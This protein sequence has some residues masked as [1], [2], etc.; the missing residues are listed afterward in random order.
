MISL[1]LIDAPEARER[2][3]AHDRRMAR[4]TYDHLERRRHGEK[5]PV[6][7]FLFDYYSLRPAQLHRW[8]PGLGSCIPSEADLPN[9]SWPFYATDERHRVHVDVDDFLSR[10]GNT[11]AQARVMLEAPLNNPAHFDCFGLHE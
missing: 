6:F 2:A 9:A 7:D 11:V 8:H 3:R 4:F 10:R 1:S 5:H